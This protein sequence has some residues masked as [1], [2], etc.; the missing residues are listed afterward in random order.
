MRAMDLQVWRGEYFFAM[1]DEQRVRLVSIPAS[2]G[3]IYDRNGE[4]LVRNVPVFRKLVIDS[5]KGL[6][7]VVIDRDEA[8]SLQKGDEAVR[9]IEAVDREYFYGKEMAHVLGYL[10]ESTEDEI[11]KSGAD[12]E[13]C[14]KKLELGSLIGR[15]GV[16]AWYDCALRGTD[17]TLLLE[18]D[19]SGGAVRE[20]GRQPPIGGNR[21]DLTIDLELQKKAYAALGEKVGAVVALDPTTGE[22]LAM[23]SGPTFDPE[24]FGMRSR[25]GARYQTN[26]ALGELFSDPA[27]PLLN[28]VTGSMYPPGSVFKMV[29][30]TAGLEEG[31]IDKH[32]TYTDTGL[33]Q[34]GSYQFRNWYYLRYGAGEGAMNV[35]RALGRST[36]TFF[37]DLGGKLGPEAMAS[38]S[39]KFGLGQATGVEIPGEA[40]GLIPDSEW[41]L[42]T[43]NERWYL[44][45]SYHMSIGQGDVLATPMQ[46]AV[47]TGVFGNEGKL[48]RPRLAKGESECEDVGVSRDNLETVIS[49]MV[50]ACSPGGTAG[51]FFNS[52]PRVGCKTGTAEFGPRDALGK[53]ATH[54]WFTVM[55]LG[56]EEGQK[57]KPLVVS[58]IVEGG[59]EGSTVAAPIAKELTDYWFNLEI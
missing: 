49:G 50:A 12:N 53:R 4:P 15:G 55:D 29:V 35:V 48:C 46:V 59:G 37:Y 57:R 32:A 30:A 14:A 28:R 13:S 8:L 47:M 3:I 6:H 33:I 9:V 39:R 54:A 26:D 16:E 40:V 1:A 27:R 10:G 42:K 41:K 18:V 2:R 19:T 5:I 36:D 17:G 56:A 11:A 51:V 25:L 21:L 43:R 20:F 31:K 45:N 24:W 34:M 38:W 58:V 22:V 23:V 52:V 7:F 44:G